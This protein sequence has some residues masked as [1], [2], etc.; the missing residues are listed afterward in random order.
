MNEYVTYTIE[1]SDLIPKK[2]FTDVKGRTYEVVGLDVVE[3]V[4]Q[5]MID[6]KCGYETA[7][8]AISKIKG[9]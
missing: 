6:N 7:L 4:K 5:Y 2:T 1:T 8:L 3:K 9:E